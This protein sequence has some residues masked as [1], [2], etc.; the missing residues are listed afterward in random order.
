[1]SGFF[2]LEQLF[3]PDHHLVYF[4]GVAIFLE[5]ELLLCLDNFIVALLYSLATITNLFQLGL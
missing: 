4:K 3:G 1:M 5:S 2:D